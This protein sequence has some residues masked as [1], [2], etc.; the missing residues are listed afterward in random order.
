M[1]EKPKLSSLLRNSPSETNP[2][3]IL[4]LFEKR[5]KSNKF[6]EVTEEYGDFLDLNFSVKFK[7]LTT[8]FR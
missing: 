2:E 7:F 6:T 1:R 5:K 4:N 8:L 3:T